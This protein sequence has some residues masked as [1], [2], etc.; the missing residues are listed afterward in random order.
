MQIGSHATRTAAEAA[1]PATRDQ[2]V[3]ETC[4]SF[5]GLLVSQ[6]LRAMKPAASG[7][8]ILPESTAQRIF[9]DQFNSAI[10]LEVA[11]ASPLGIAQMLYQAAV[12]DQPEGENDES[13]RPDAR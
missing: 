9:Q 8:G 2:R 7:A 12:G 1:P 4:V 11:H 3:W 10:G 5:E 13:N 6:M